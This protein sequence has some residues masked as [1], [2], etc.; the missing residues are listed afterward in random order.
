MDSEFW[1]WFIGLLVTAA[2][3][4]A[5]TTRY[6]QNQINATAKDMEKGDD[7]LHERINRVRDEFV[8]RDD[9]DGHITRVDR[10]LTEVRESQ[11]AIHDLL[12]ETLMAG[13]RRP[14]RRPVKRPKPT[15]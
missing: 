1:K 2:T 4:G 12:I 5:V 11:T 6:L 13:K 10:A 8:R 3:A 9:L 7:R 14:R 15:P